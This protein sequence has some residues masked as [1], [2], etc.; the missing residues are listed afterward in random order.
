MV[1]FTVLHCDLD[2]RQV[3][4]NLYISRLMPLR[5]VTTQVAV[6]IHVV[7]DTHVESYDLLKVGVTP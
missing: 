7:T 4:L 6:T 3:D 5:C 1:L 2:A